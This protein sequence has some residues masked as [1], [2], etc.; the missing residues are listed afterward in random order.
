MCDLFLKLT[1]WPLETLKVL[2]IV[3]RKMTISIFVVNI[4]KTS[5]DIGKVYITKNIAWKIPH[6]KVPVQFASKVRD[7]T[8]RGALSSCSHY[9]NN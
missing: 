7:L 5:G 8:V 4:Y 6:Q 1:V 9:S 2:V 3:N